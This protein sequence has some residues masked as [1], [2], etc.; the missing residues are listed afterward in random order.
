MSSFDTT[1]IY[2]SYVDV[3]S[4]FFRCCVS[5]LE[6]LCASRE[7]SMSGK[8]VVTLVQFFNKC[9]LYFFLTDIRRFSIC[10]RVN[11]RLVSQMRRLQLSD[12]CWYTWKCLSLGIIHVTVGL[13]LCI[14]KLMTN[15]VHSYKLV[16]LNLAQCR[17]NLQRLTLNSFWFSGF[18]QKRFCTK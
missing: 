5:L 1:D 2:R 15:I 7:I 11:L 3:P 18:L 16:F 17:K 9:G 13:R 14:E 8:R 10:S 12:K 6:I 4:S